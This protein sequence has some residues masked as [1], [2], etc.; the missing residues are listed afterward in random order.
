MI[1]LATY[2][3]GTS[4]FANIQVYAVRIYAQAHDASTRAAVINELAD[5][6]NI[7]L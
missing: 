3:T 7:T 2:Q 1:K 5:Q 4:G 6:Y